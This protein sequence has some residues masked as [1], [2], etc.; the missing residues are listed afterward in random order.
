MSAA[1]LPMGHLVRDPPVRALGLTLVVVL[2]MRKLW[3]K[4]V[5]AFSRVRPKSRSSAPKFKDT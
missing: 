2:Q 1:A 3:A 5:T 4:K